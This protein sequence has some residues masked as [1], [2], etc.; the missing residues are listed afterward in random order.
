MDKKF[1]LQVI[2]KLFKLSDVYNEER[3][4]I[5]NVW[6]EEIFGKIILNRVPNICYDNLKNKSV[7][8]SREFDNAFEVLCKKNVIETEYY[9]KAVI[10]VSGI[11]EEANFLYAMLKGAFLITHVYEKGYRQSNDID[12]L[13]KE[14]DVEKC[15]QV[16]LENGFIQG[17]IRGRKIIKATREEI[18]LS[19]MNYGETIPF[20][21]FWEGRYLC[22]DINFSLD[23]KPMKDNTVICKMLEQ[24]VEV[25][26]EN[27]CLRTLNVTDFIIHLCLHLYKEATT[28]DWVKRRKDLNLY[29]FSDLNVMFH[30][31]VDENISVLLSERIK[32]FGVERECYYA[33]VHTQDIYENLKNNVDYEKLLKR[34]K[35][36]C[37]EYLS[38]IVDPIR[39]KT[40]KY[41]MSFREWFACENRVAELQEID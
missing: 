27:T 5:D 30:E 41:N 21:K 1:K 20:C 22:V 7:W 18:I 39:K 16:L 9:E 8:I 13:V 15:Q 12:L 38:Q 11:F 3:I 17:H 37:L 4:E 31:Y 6:A 32:E 19:R 24:R 23:Y 34:I 40:Y 14:E 2:D 10:Y 28:Y 35:P 36:E 25:P 33:L 26:L 29:K